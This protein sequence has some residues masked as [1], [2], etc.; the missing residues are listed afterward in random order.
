[1]DAR[2]QEI[3]DYMQ[4]K[5]QHAINDMVGHVSFPL[6]WPLDVVQECDHAVRILVS[7]FRNQSKVTIPF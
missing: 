7:A 4:R 6:S 5:F 3:A 2:Q 1:M